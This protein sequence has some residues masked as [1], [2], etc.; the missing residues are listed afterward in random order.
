MSPSE[1]DKFIDMVQ[2]MG[3]D[4]PESHL[5]N[6]VEE[7]LE[8]LRSPDRPRMIIKCSN[9]LD[10]VARSDMTTY[11]LLN[12]STRKADWGTTERRLRNLKIP[13]AP[14][15]PYIVQE[16]IGGEGVSEWCTHATVLDGKI[17]S[18]VCCPSNDMLMTYRNATFSHVGIRALKWTED[19]LEALGKSDRW[20]DTRLDGEFSM[21]FM[22]QPEQ[23]DRARRDPQTI[24]K[25]Q[26][27][28]RLVVIECN[29]R[30]HTAI[31]L[32]AP[33]ENLGSTFVRHHAQTSKLAKAAA[34]NGKGGHQAERAAWGTT[35]EGGRPHDA[36]PLQPN[37]NQLPVGWIGHDLPAGIIPR[38]LPKRLCRAVHPFWVFP[39]QPS[40][41]SQRSLPPADHGPELGD[42]SSVPASTFLLGLLSDPVWSWNDPWPFFAMY[43]LHW[44]Y[45]LLHQILLRR[46]KWSRIN[47]ST[48][49]IF[50]C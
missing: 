20:K 46:R 2:E 19:F 33:R 30:V 12:P 8:L 16:F 43:H 21:D 9:V 34:V 45:L 10:D 40:N 24:D 47:L 39:N 32:L 23:I 3:L 38:L 17:R 1:Q 27:L 15:T 42:L 35:G 7:L 5:V 26:H 28:G 31:V 36:A 14:A 48:S 11:P 29:P 4:V 37:T 6:S 25:S 44:P 41:E 13:I 50:E 18:F 22:H 49:R